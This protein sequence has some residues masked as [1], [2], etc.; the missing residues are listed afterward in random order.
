MKLNELTSKELLQH[1]KSQ[2]TE[3]YKLANM[4]MNH[5]FFFYLKKY[6]ALIF[7]WIATII[8]SIGFYESSLFSNHP[9]LGSFLTGYVI[10]MVGIY[11][12]LTLEDN[13]ELSDEGLQ[14]NISRQLKLINSL[15]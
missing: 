5:R 2:L 15:K 9:F 7:Y 11:T 8:F 10:V 13:L 6:K 14:E 3:Y 12:A 1:T 4:D